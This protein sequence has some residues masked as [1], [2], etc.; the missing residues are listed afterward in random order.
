MC[1][2]VCECV[3]EPVHSVLFLDTGAAAIVKQAESRSAAPIRPP[4]DCNSGLLEHLV[5]GRLL[6]GCWGDAL[7][8]GQRLQLP[9]KGR[10]SRVFR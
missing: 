8:V 7:L 2:C 3:C 4:A 1:V 9:V 6:N 10:E 5:Q